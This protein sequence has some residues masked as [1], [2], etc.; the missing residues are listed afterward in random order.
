M[1]DC[2]PIVIEC[3]DTHPLNI[4][5]VDPEA[6]PAFL[7]ELGLRVVLESRPPWTNILPNIQAYLRQHIPYTVASPQVLIGNNQTYPNWCW[8]ID[9]S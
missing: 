7:S 5:Q 9:A 4:E 6:M 8:T 1:F 3:T 2:T